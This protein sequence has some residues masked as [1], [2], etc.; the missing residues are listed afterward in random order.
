MVTNEQISSALSYPEYRDLI[1]KLFAEG[2]T[3]GHDQS[4]AKIDY[5]KINLQRIKRLEKT[6]VIGHELRD[7]LARIKGNYYWVIITEGWCG[8][9]S[10]NVSLLHLLEKE[11][12]NI[13]LK[14]VLRDDN[15]DVMDQY[16]TNGSRS[17]PKLVCFE[18]ESL[19]ELFTWGP[20]PAPLQ[21]LVKKLVAD[22]VSKDERGIITQK[23]Y[24]EDKTRTLQLEFASLITQYM[25]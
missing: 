23:W 22:G 1:E 3:T 15:P 2:K 14:I 24:N 12:P 19:R 25:P 5:A 10:Q 9:S 6:L 8:D 4:P 16:L 11:C 21:E 18:K 17:I 20:R 13:E 7:A